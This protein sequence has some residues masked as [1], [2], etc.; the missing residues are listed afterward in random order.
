MPGSVSS[1]GV[2]LSPSRVHARSHAMS[3]SRPAVRVVLEG[4]SGTAQQ[5]SPYRVRREDSQ[6]CGQAEELP[7]EPVRVGTADVDDRGVRAFGAVGTDCRRDQSQGSFHGHREADCRTERVGAGRDGAGDEQCGVG[8]VDELHRMPSGRRRHPSRPTGPRSAGAAPAAVS[9]VPTG[10]LGRRRDSS[11]APPLV[12][13]QPPPALPRHQGSAGVPGIRHAGGTR[14][15]ARGRT[16]W[17]SRCPG[18]WRCRA[19]RC[20]R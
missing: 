20:G 5:R 19:A 12:A 16:R 6:R 1:G 14:P 11:S 4:F 2:S 10:R 17:R 7:G 18:A 15:R 13:R 8:W 9:A 3:L